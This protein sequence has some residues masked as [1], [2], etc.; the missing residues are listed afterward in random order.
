MP[1]ESED[2]EAKG[3]EAGSGGGSRLHT[4]VPLLGKFLLGVIFVMAALTVLSELGVDIGPLIAGAGIFGLA[5]GFGA[6]T[7]VKDV[8]SGV[9]FLFDDAFRVGEYV[10]V[11]SVA[12]SVE[13]VSIRSLRLRHQNGPLHTIP[14]GEIQHLTNYSRDWAIMK[15]EI[16]VPFETDTEKV[17]K[18]VKKVG[19]KLLTDPV[20]GPN[21]LAPLKSQGVNRIDDSAFIL[22]VKFTAK[23]G[24]QFGLRREVF[25]RIQEAFAEN[26]IRF[27]PRRVIVDTSGG[28]PAPAAVVAAAEAAIAEEGAEGSAK[29]GEKR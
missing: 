9:F 20:H 24:Q 3:G 23:P 14:F 4:L 7:L 11:G 12:G 16:R 2:S 28:E 26:G 8:I 13:H 19:Q 25:R 27:A 10:N 6:Q 18:I 29:E 22:R 17:R 5:I 1:V 21:F 15:L